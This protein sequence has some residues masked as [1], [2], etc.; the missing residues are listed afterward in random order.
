MTFHTE[1]PQISG[2][3][4]RN[5]VTHMIWHLRFV[6]TSGFTKIHCTKAQKSFG[7]EDCMLQGRKLIAMLAVMQ[8]S[9]GSGCTGLQGWAP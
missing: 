5:L 6:C 2:A 1:D 7:R 8:P 9:A 4:L 3:K